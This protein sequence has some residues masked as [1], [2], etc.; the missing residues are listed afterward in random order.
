[1]N[2]KKIIETEE[3]DIYNN[4]TLVV[5]IYDEQGEIINLEF[6]AEIKSETIYL[7]E[8]VS[9]GKYSIS[10]GLPQFI[11]HPL[12]PSFDSK[13]KFEITLNEY[14]DL[15]NKNILERYYFFKEKQKYE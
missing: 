14:K 5:G 3:K 4:E 15:L 7:N 9:E 8:N 2:T 13:Y 6:Y 11:G 10:F 1:M 12:E